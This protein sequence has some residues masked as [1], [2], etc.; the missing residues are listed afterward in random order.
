[1][2]TYLLDLFLTHSEVATDWIIALS[3]LG[4]SISATIIGARVVNWLKSLYLLVLHNTAHGT[5]IHIDTP[6]K[7]VPPVKL[8][9]WRPG[10]KF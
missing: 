9:P 3:C 2:Y 6:L 8:Y 5:Q 4:F 7:K 10:D 1:M